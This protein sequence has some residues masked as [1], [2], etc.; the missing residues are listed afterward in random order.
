MKISDVK[1][2]DVQNVYDEMMT[3]GLSTNTVHHVNAP[4]SMAMK[5]AIELNYITK[6]P[7]DFVE[8]PKQIKEETKALSPK[9][10]L[11]FLDHAKFN[12]HGLVFEFAIISG[13]RPEEYLSLRWSD[14][15]FLRHTSSVSRALVWLKGGGYEFGE[16][17]NKK[18]R[19]TVS[20]P[21][22]LILKLK[23]H[24]RNQLEQR[25]ELG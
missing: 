4:L 23:K 19:R 8:L 6:N 1:I 7:C 21:E 15:D 12:K 5:K 17:K 3:D 2:Q 25:L 22:D 11:H 20:L 13:M 24:R 10:V 14:I 9:Q 18:S 16:T